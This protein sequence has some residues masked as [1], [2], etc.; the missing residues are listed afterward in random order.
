MPKLTPLTH[1]HPS[2]LH[3]FG[4]F[5]RLLLPLAKSNFSIHQLMQLLRIEGGLARAGSCVRSEACNGISD[6]QKLAIKEGVSRRHNIADGLNERLLGV[7]DDFC[8]L[9]GQRFLR[10]LCCST[11]SF[12]IVPIGSVT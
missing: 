2:P 11:V 10:I 3:I 8:K 7:T 12:L 4:K 5:H 6:Q 9:W 1:L